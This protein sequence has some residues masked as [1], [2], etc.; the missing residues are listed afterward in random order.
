MYVWLSMFQAYTIHMFISN[1]IGMCLFY[2]F[3]GSEFGMVCDW[4]YRLPHYL[5]ANSCGR[6]LGVFLFTSLTMHGLWMFMVD[7]S[8]QLMGYIDQQTY[9]GGT[10]LSQLPVFRCQEPKVHQTS[11][12]IA[13]ACW[14]HFHGVAFRMK[15][16]S[17][18]LTKQPQ[19]LF[20]PAYTTGVKTAKQKLQ[21]VYWRCAPSSSIIFGPVFGQLQSTIPSPMFHRLSSPGHQLGLR[22][23]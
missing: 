21:H 22:T 10:T 16:R 17:N 19:Q 2:H 13:V 9:P 6:C 18:L 23:E 12:K 8:N 3:W 4:V 11:S 15:A 1:R 20:I 5:H 7:I 14:G